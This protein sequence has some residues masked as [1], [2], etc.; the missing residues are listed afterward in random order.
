[1]KP[2]LLLFAAVVVC[3]GLPAPALADG[4]L[5]LNEA[6]EIALDSAD[7]TVTRYGE[8]AAALEDRAIAES[9]LPDPQVKLGLRNMPTDSFDFTQ[10]SMTQVEVGLQQ[11]FPA[12]DTRSLMRGQREAEADAARANQ[13]LEERRLVLETRLAWLEAFYWSSAM[14]TLRES[15]QAVSRL[16]EVIRT[17]FSSGGKAGQDVYRSGLELSL[18]DDR[19]MEASGQLDVAR[20]TLGRYVSPAN[21]GRTLPDGITALP[22]A[23]DLAT[24]EQR[25]PRH[26]SIAVSD[27]KLAAESSAVSIAEE[28]YEPQWMLD[29]GYGLRA[30]GRADFA[31][32]GITFS[33]PLFTA[34]RQDRQLSAARHQR[35]AER[36]ERDAK[37]L[38]L[39]ESLTTTFAEW[40]KLGERMDLYQDAILQRASSTTQAALSAYRNDVADFND[41]ITGRLSELDARL[42]LLRITVD[43]AKAQARLLFLDGMDHE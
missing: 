34:K 35:Q 43:R 28:K 6:V 13:R 19:L 42:K 33:V 29:I 18:L 14:E 4:V 25:L 3:G 5:S 10:E 2:R 1:M 8:R 21:A 11:A 23:A 9:Q 26:P 24:L 41:L 7:P 20:A 37:L 17:R 39:H 30:G 16:A 22:P 38:E 40:Q 36:L 27:A 32:A 31:S 15:R 12:G